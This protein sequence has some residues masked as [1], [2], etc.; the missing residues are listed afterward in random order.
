MNFM[1]EYPTTTSNAA[2]EWLAYLEKKEGISIQH[3]RNGPE[4]RIGSKKRPVDGFCRY[5]F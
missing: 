3:S 2:T 5:A 4:I 1:K